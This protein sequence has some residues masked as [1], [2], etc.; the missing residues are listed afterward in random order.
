[1]V[2][3]TDT[4]LTIEKIPKIQFGQIEGLGRAESNCTGR[5]VDARGRLLCT[6][7]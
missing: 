2:D 1:M 7:W 4:G 5:H 6:T 3:G